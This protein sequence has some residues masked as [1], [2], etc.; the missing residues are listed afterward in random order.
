MD[1]SWIQEVLSDLAE[2]AEQAG[3]PRTAVELRNTE[4]LY[5]LETVQRRPSTFDFTEVPV[6]LDSKTKGFPSER[7]VL[8]SKSADQF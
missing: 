6:K 3:L 4:L 7:G 8:M 5:H 1:H 2:F